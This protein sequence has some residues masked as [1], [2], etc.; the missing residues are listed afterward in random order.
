M[1]KCLTFLL[2][3]LLSIGSFAEETLKDNYNVQ[4]IEILENS[5]IPEEVLTNLMGTKI[6]DE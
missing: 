1:K 4:S 2:G 6:G 5:E 3:A